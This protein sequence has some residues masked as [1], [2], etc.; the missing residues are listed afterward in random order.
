MNDQ[1]VEPKVLTPAEIL[2]LWADK[3]E[4]NAEEDFA[5]AFVI[6][7]PTGDAIASLF[8]DPERDLSTFFTLIKTRIDTAVDELN[9]KQ[10]QGVSKGYR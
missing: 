2:R 4:R 6:L 8:I 1:S 10:R 7:P 5:G 3:I 9:D